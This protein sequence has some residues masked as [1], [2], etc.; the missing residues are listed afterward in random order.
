LVKELREEGIHA[1]GEY[2][3]FILRKTFGEIDK[4]SETGMDSFL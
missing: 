4:L 3:I 1:F 2:P